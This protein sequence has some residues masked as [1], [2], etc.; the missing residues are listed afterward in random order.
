VEG[1]EKGGEIKLIFN[2]QL[3]IFI[4]FPIIKFS[5]DWKLN[6]CGSGFPSPIVVEDK[7]SR[8]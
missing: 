8:E 5:T 3:P 7:L 6:Q 2:D 4:E 1:N